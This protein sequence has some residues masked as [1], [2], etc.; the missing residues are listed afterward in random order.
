M[1]S[2]PYYVP[3]GSGTS[4]GSV[5]HN[6]VPTSKV[7]HF[8]TLV[9]GLALRLG[10]VNKACNLIKVPVTRWQRIADGE[11]ALTDLIAR[12]ILAAHKAHKHLKPKR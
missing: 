3:T 4:D 2:N 7:P 6:A 9:N 12:R 1:S 5:Q 10:S 11:V 8:V